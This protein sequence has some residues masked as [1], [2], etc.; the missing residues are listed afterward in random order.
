VEVLGDPDREGLQQGA[1]EECH[2]AH[3]PP[4][5]RTSGGKAH[6]GFDALCPVIQVVKHF[7]FLVTGCLLILFQKKD[8]LVCE[9]LL[10]SW[11][12]SVT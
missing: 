5:L 1:Q 6:R 11:D 12:T 10:L 7:A 4:Q 8:G 3:M 2:E 9:W